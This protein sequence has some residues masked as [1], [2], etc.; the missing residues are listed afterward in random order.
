[1]FS[2]SLSLECETKIRFNSVLLDWGVRRWDGT[3]ASCYVYFLECCLIFKTMNTTRL[4]EGLILC[5]MIG[6]SEGAVESGHR[7]LTTHG[8]EGTR[9]VISPTRIAH[10]SI[11]TSTSTIKYSAIATPAYQPI[12][13]NRNHQLVVKEG[14]RAPGSW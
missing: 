3:R 6:V 14:P 13:W 7:Q 8:C 4:G 5:C 9:T 10:T 11:A 1:M 2:G 12:Q